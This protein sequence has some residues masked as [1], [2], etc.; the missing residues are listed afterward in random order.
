[1]AVGKGLRPQQP[2]DNTIDRDLTRDAIAQGLLFDDNALK[3][4]EE[5]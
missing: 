3:F 2:I 1:M 5:F 4:H